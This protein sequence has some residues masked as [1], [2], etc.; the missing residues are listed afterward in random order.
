MNSPSKQSNQNDSENSNINQIQNKE[1]DSLKKEISEL[2]SQR[3]QDK[4]N[5]DELKSLFQTEIKKLQNQIKSLS[6]EIVILKIKNKKKEDDNINNDNIINEDNI[7]NSI[8]IDDN[9][10]SLECLSRKLSID[11]TQG[12]DRTSLDIAIR[13]NSKEKYPENSC[14]ICDSKKSHLLCDDVELGEL[15][16]NQQKIITIWFKNL[17]CISKG[18]YKCYI[19]LK[20]GNRVYNSSKI[21]LTLNVVSP[22]NIQ[23]NI[24][25]GSLASQNNPFLQNNGN[26]FNNINISNPFISNNN[27]N[28]E[29]QNNIVSIFR[30]MFDLYDDEAYP[31]ERIKEAMMNN[32]NDYNKA[33]ASL[34]N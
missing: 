13:N 31:D 23:N 18:I 10:Y 25:Q 5:I 9:K 20:I 17:K 2:K 21:E 24:F 4:K 16:P 34:Y 29:D 14:L 3:E 7:E 26:N 15:E 19:I 30:A 1:I 33:F 27:L 11:I 32:D 22:Q 28:Q 12:T 8:E 6:E